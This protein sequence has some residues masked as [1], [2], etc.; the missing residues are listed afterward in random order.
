MVTRKVDEQS[1]AEHRN[2]GSISTAAAA[3]A[4]QLLR[5]RVLQEAR[6][7][8]K[9][10]LFPSGAAEGKQRFTVWAVTQYI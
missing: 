1:G 3:A 5:H 9:G 6:E 2:K 10:S 8:G 7:E 4:A